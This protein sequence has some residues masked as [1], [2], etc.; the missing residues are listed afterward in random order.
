MKKVLFSVID[1][2]GNEIKLLKETFE[3]H[4]IIRHPEMENHIQAIERAIKH[5]LYIGN[6]I[7]SKDSI[8][9]LSAFPNPNTPY[10]IVAVKKIKA[11]NKIILTAFSAK[12]LG[13][14]KINKILWQ[15]KNPK[16]LIIPTLQ[17]R[18]N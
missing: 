13:L 16:N 12:N 14:N 7:K 17:P 18:K 1:P 8:M 4:I 10:I 15:Q 6:G 5:P 9:Y 2:L 3:K 11:S